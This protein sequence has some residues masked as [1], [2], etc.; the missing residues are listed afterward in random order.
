M[1]DRGFFN[2]TRLCSN[3][4]YIM[5]AARIERED[6]ARKERRRERGGMKEIE[7]GMKERKRGGMKERDEE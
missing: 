3:L 1:Q 2:F 5:T 4:F 6:I 7:I